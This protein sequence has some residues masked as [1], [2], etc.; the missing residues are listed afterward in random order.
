MTKAPVHENH[1]PRPE[2]DDVRRARQAAVVTPETNSV[3]AQEFL[4]E[5][6]RERI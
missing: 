5:P 2:N 1:H 4:Y 6:F 3:L